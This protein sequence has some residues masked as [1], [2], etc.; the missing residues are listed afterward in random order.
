[1]AE[2]RITPANGVIVLDLNLENVATV[3]ISPVLA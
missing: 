1:M 3:T 2:K